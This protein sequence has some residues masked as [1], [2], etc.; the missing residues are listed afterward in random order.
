MS[1]FEE[2]GVERQYEARTV[3]AAKKALHY[4][5]NRCSTTGRHNNCKNC[6]IA[7]AHKDVLTFVLA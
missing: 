7:S 5:C 6:A 4:S 3:N 1:I 2:R